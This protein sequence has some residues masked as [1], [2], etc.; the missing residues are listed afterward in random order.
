MC[1]P[2]VTEYRNFTS[3]PPSFSQ[4]SLST[5]RKNPGQT[6]S[7]FVEFPSKDDGNGE[8]DPSEQTPSQLTAE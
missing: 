7:L 3:N 1:Q 5:A 2:A 4:F 8:D 6:Q